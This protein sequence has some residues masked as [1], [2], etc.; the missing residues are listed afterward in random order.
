MLFSKV[1]FEFA[2]LTLKNSGVGKAQY[3]YWLILAF[4]VFFDIGQLHL[5][6]TIAPVLRCEWKLS[7]QWETLINVGGYFFSALGKFNF[8]RFLNKDSY[9]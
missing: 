8:S 4:I 1:C 6:S 5:I 3:S 7:V 9:S 2:F